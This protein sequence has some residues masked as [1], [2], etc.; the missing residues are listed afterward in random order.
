MVTRACR[1]LGLASVLAVLTLAPTAL[2]DVAGP[3]TSGTGQGG[4]TS[5]GGGGAGG[6]GGSGASADDSGCDCGIER[7]NQDRSVAALMLALGLA[8]WARSWR[9]S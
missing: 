4:S 6:D 8:A 1:V 2:G 3:V 9:K 5:S 7:A